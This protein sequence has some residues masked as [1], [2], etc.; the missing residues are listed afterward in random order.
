ML[1]LY[2]RC[3]RKLEG[4]LQ[5]NCDQMNNNETNKVLLKLRYLK[6]IT[7]LDGLIVILEIGIFKKK[8]QL[9][10]PT[11]DRIVRRLFKF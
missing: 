6:L 5:E 8:E 10:Y 3:F 7:D 1:L 4:R 2:S 11:N 9:A